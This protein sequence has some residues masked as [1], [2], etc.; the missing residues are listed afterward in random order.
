MFEDLG[1]GAEPPEG[2]QFVPTALVRA[3]KHDLRHKSRLIALGDRYKPEELTSYAGVVNL[4]SVRILCHVAMLNKLEL[5]AADV[6][7]AYL[8]ALTDEK[9]LY[10]CERR[11]LGRS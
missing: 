5:W 4:Q 2:Y 11:A 6:S 1:E 10:D 8:E 3:V 9:G 7:S